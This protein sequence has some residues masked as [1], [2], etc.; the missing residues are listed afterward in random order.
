MRSRPRSRS[1]GIAALRQMH[2][3]CAGWRLTGC[4][5]TIAPCAPVR[6]LTPCPL[7]GTYPKGKRL[8]DFS[9]ACGSLRNQFACHPEGG[10][11]SWLPHRG[12]SEHDLKERSDAQIIVS[13]FPARVSCRRLRGCICVEDADQLKAQGSRLKARDYDR[14]HASEITTT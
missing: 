4:S 7:R 5:V 8:T 13:R 6:L 14:K 9:V 11:K 1:S 2:T 3:D 10:S 12:G